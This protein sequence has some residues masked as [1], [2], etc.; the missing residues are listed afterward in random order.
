MSKW[1]MNEWVDE[2]TTEKKWKNES[3]TLSGGSLL[4]S[5]TMKAIFISSFLINRNNLHI[6]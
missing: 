5:G 3:Q 2:Q 6:Y 4:E 1:T